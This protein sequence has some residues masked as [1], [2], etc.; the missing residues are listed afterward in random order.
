VTSPLNLKKTYFDTKLYFPFS[1]LFYSGE[2]EG[3]VGFQLKE[4]KWLLRKILGTKI[5]D[6]VKMFHMVRRVMF[7]FFFFFFYLE[8]TLNNRYELEKNFYLGWISGFW[9][10]LLVF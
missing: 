5:V 3:V 4:R 7:R 10:G 9:G 6:F 2:R 8:N 1:F